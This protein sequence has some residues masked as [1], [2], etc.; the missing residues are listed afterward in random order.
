LGSLNAQAEGFLSIGVHL[1][2]QSVLPGFGES[3]LVLRPDSQ[4]GTVSHFMVGFDGFDA[5]RL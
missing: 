2:V 1:S 3:M 5:E 4:P